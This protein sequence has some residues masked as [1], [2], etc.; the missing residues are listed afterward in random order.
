MGHERK[1]WR[2][3][4]LID[5]AG[6][7]CYLLVKNQSPRV[8][9]AVG[10]YEAH[11]RSARKPP[12][13]RRNI[14]TE[15][16]Y[17]YTWAEARQI[18]LDARL[19]TG[20]GL[21][22]PEIRG[23]LHWLLNV[24][25]TKSG[26]ALSAATVGNMGTD[27]RK[28]L[29]LLAMQRAAVNGELPVSVYGLH[30]ITSYHKDSRVVT[31]A[32]VLR[33]LRISGRHTHIQ[34]L[35]DQAAA[36]QVNGT[37]YPEPDFDS[38][39]EKSYQFDSKGIVY[40]RDNQRI[41]E[42]WDALFVI[43]DRTL[44][45]KGILTPK[46]YKN[47]TQGV[48]SNAL[49]GHHGSGKANDSLFKRYDIRDPRTGE[50][51]KFTSNQLRQWLNTM[52]LRGGLTHEQA[53]LVM[54]HDPGT[55]AQYDQRDYFERELLLQQSVRDGYAVGHVADVYISL[56]DHDLQEAEAFLVA[57]MRQYSIMPHGACVRDLKLDPCPNH[58]ACFVDHSSAQP[59]VCAH[60]VVDSRH[61]QVIE[62]LNAL[63]R[64]QDLML[65]MLPVTSPQH[66]HASLVRRNIQHILTALPHLEAGHGQ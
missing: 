44:T 31:V 14:V 1:T 58:L 18:D 6:Q 32:A 4:A 61:P 60:L 46:G 65:S 5:R 50:V 7:A 26:A 11:L 16:A 12:N 30:P 3:A 41:L 43:E 21:S 48:L 51:A 37:I 9:V 2:V 22:V 25:Q 10:I 33:N 40:D 45:P 59:D 49:C 13:T 64:Q 23:F 63:S 8:S 54:G 34:P 27:N 57:S 15:C 24:H 29:H 20:A 17:L 39:L 35:V 52:Y 56:A 47:V 36:H 55:N 53:A 28:V 19:L 42:P 38:T 62:H 66:G